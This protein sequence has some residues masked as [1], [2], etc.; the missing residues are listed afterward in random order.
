[1]NEVSME[2]RVYPALRW[3]EDFAI[4]QRYVFGRWE[5]LREQMLEF[6]ALYDPEPFHLDEDAARRLGWDGL[7]VSGL[8]VV[9]IW[10]RLSTDAFPN[11]ATVIS[12]GWDDV[13]WRLPVY[14]GD[15]LTSNTEI[16]GTRVLGSRPGEGLV[17]L[18]NRIVRGDGEVVASL[19]S[20][21]FVR[22][23]T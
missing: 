4:G 8:Q 5:M 3:F 17:R 23:R 18:D 7:M 1:M 22:C 10:R 15:V 14:E 20:N 2:P 16:I 6:A 11:C 19:V 13:R 12:P 21:W 9:S